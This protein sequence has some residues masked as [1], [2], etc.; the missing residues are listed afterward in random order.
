MLNFQIFFKY[1]VL[2]KIMII[3]FYELGGSMDL[4]LMI[5]LLCGM[6]LVT[7]GLLGYMIFYAIKGLYSLLK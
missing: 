4:F 6:N 1:V 5:T 3:S 7:F 2:Y